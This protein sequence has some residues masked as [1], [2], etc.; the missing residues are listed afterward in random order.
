[1]M[2]EALF[3]PSQG[4]GF[5]QQVPVP[6]PPRWEI[7]SMTR[8]EGRPVKTV[9]AFGLLTW[10]NVGRPIYKENEELKTEYVQTS[11]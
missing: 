5:V 8:E 7:W 10:D 11:S 6:T 1:M 4:F 9:R 3:I 2:Q